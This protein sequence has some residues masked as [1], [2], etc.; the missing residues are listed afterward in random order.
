MNSRIRGIHMYRIASTETFQ[1]YTIIKLT[2]PAPSDYY[3]GF[4]QVNGVQYKIVYPHFNSQS[5]FGK[6]MDTIVIQGTGL[7]AGQK[8]TFHATAHSL[9]DKSCNNSN[10]LADLFFGGNI[11]SGFPELLYAKQIKVFL[12]VDHIREPDQIR[13]IAVKL[14]SMDCIEFVFWGKQAN[15][16]HNE[17]DI[18]DIKLHPDENDW[19]LTNDWDEVDDFVDDIAIALSVREY[20]NTTIFLLY[21]DETLF[22]NVLSLL[23]RYTESDLNI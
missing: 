10:Q 7:C 14:M 2:K 9:P 3:P 1:D 19:V 20:S 15:T 22:L 21:D 18:A 8:I 13:N 5:I 12:I 4:I 23:D 6:P 11:Q 16:W 17:T